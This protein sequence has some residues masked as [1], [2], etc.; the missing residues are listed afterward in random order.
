MQAVI[1]GGPQGVTCKQCLKKMRA[2]NSMVAPR[3]IIIHKPFGQSNLFA[4]CNKMIHHGSD[5][6]SEVESEITCPTCLK[7]MKISKGVGL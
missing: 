6:L 1:G 4:I 7:L 2:K 5:S 3:A